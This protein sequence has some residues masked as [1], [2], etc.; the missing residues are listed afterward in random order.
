MG[1]VLDQQPELIVLMSRAPDHYLGPYDWERAFWTDPR[2]NER[3]VRYQVRKGAL[4]HFVL[5]RRR[6]WVAPDAPQ[7]SEPSR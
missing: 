7:P 4:N 6:D 1:Y 5:F 3:Y 2:F